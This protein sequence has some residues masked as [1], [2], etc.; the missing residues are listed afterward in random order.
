MTLPIKSG[1]AFGVFPNNSLTNPPKPEDAGWYPITDHNRGPLQF[2]YDNI[3]KDIRMANGF[4][5]KYVVAQKRT[6]ATDWNMVPSVA[7]VTNI[8]RNVSASGNFNT[9]VATLTADGNAGAG[10]LKEFYESNIFIPIWIKITHSTASVTGTYAAG[11]FPTPVYSSQMNSSSAF[12]YPTAGN[13][14]AT[15]T[16]SARPDIYYGYMTDF[17]YQVQKRLT[18]TDYVNMSIKFVEA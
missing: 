7:S 11:F 17:S 18:Y 5:R 13:N 2:G 16:G 10:W 6:V 4:M 9:N 8:I 1:I 12:D 14:Y 3:E 15:I